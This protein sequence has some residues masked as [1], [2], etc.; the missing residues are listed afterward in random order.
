MTISTINVLRMISPLLYYMS[1]HGVMLNLFL[2]LR[3]TIKKRI[4]GHVAH[5][6]VPKP[7]IA[8]YEINVRLV[9]SVALGVVC[10]TVSSHK[11]AAQRYVVSDAAFLACAHPEPPYY[12]VAEDLSGMRIYTHMHAYIGREY[13]MLKATA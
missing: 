8:Q 10:L 5:T 9:V 4:V 3:T 11:P 13:I 6:V 7:Y 12:D 1:L 2:Q